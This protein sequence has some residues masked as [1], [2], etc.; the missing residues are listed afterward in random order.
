MDEFPIQSVV[1]SPGSGS[2]D[3]EI[4]DGLLHALASTLNA[5]SD[6]MEVCPVLLCVMFQGC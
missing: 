3:M 5:A 6:E 2:R 1:V 4:P